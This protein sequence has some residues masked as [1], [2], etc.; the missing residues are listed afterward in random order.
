MHG[1]QR[2][3]LDGGGEVGGGERRLT[4][5]QDAQPPAKCVSGPRK[6]C[7]A[8]SR[9]CVCVLGKE[10][11]REG[12]RSRQA[13]RLRRNRI[14]SSAALDRSFRAR[15]EPNPVWARNLI[16]IIISHEPSRGLPS[17]LQRY[18]PTKR[19]RG[20]V[21]AR[22]LRACRHAHTPVQPNR[23]DLVKTL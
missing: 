7:C 1:D 2:Q 3:Q 13:E 22:V 18:P 14:V 17:F 6:P 16:L 4:S 15:G 12:G 5:I 9:V 8:G 23:F 11:W 19:T 21:R 20:S 10:R